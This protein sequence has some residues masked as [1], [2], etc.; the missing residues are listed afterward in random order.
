VARWPAFVLAG[1]LGVA[2]AVAVILRRGPP[3][4]PEDV[5]LVAPASDGTRRMAERLRQLAA[6][7]DPA[8][9][10]FLNRRR[11]E[12]YRRALT[13]DLSPPEELETRLR[14]G[15]ELLQAGES[16]DAIAAFTKAEA[17]LAR[18]DAD[19]RTAHRALLH[20]LLG[21][22]HLRLGEQENC[23]A[24]HTSESCLFPIPKGGVHTLE[25][26]SRRAIEH[27]NAVLDQDP[28]DL[29]SIWLLNLAH[30]TL[31]DYPAALPP[32][33]RLPP[34]VFRSDSDIGRFRE[35]AS[36]CGLAALGRAG[37]A[38]MEDFDGDGFLDVVCSSWGLDDPIRF[39]RSRGDGVFEERT[40]AAG[41]EGLTGG[42]NLVHADYDNDGDADVLVL[43]GAWF[44]RWGRQP[45][46][47]L[48]N[49]GDGSFDDVTEAAGLLSFH[50]T[51]TAA[52]GDYD[53]DGWL[54]LF[55]G[56][57]S[58]PDDSHPCELF[59]SQDGRFVECAAEA[60]VA[61]IG[62]VKGVAWGDYD[63]D[64]RLDLYL[65]RLG[66]PNVLY[67]NLGPGSAAGSAKAS[68]APQP[69]RFE[70]QSARAGVTEPADGFPTW[71]WDF[72]N[73]GWLDIFAASYA[74]DGTEADVAADYL[75]LKTER[76]KPRLYRNR[77]DG[78][79]EDV[80]QA[81]RLDRVLV[82]M[83]ANFG[84]LDN[85][86]WLDF[87]VGTGEPSL[88]ALMPNRMFRSREG[89]FFED[90]TT[91]GGFGHLQKGHGVAFGDIDNDGDQDVYA[92]LGGAYEGDA[93]Q[94]ALFE[95]PGHG[96][97][98]I[99]LRL[100]GTRSNRGAVGARIELE[101][102]EDGRTRRIFAVVSTGGSFGSSSLQQELGLGKA[103]SV[104]RLKVTWPA[105]GEVQVF[106][107]VPADRV[108]EVTEGKAGWRA[109]ELRRIRLGG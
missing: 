40:E 109:V 37:G 33:R 86:G 35:V 99:T 34:E 31:G 92:V 18:L 68:T 71:F 20:H 4:I 106:E 81:A 95:N 75:G 19:E 49:R 57:E 16:E 107:D 63:N 74:W 104:R 26:G 29:V 102:E 42:L 11:A 103:R 94:N 89:R 25:R 17:L 64:G 90:V 32:A 28:D 14:L 21:L 23:I 97:H 52:W 70:D 101:V 98:W 53:N 61:C 91:S 3:A 82:A 38:A 44:R 5:P 51:Q 85:D 22:A 6:E 96:N 12:I 45:N 2:V 55:V 39:F 30:M 9:V 77:G 65:S 41:L 48:R 88:S 108:V 8:E 100:A 54:D 73:D 84:D 43:R 83:G 56:N 72:D 80:T 59:R 105:T 87:Y 78:T 7:L 27:F 36:S 24:R 60:G 67:R 66:E 76:A 46:S 1:A 15:I 69:W 79:F 93:F 58:T 10:P 47:L 13:P 50:P 62:Y